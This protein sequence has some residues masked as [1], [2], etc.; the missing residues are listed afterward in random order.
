VNPAGFGNP[1]AGLT[2]NCLA[3]VLMIAG[4]LST[5]VKIN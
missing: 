2:L 4:F 1:A 5:W 3:I